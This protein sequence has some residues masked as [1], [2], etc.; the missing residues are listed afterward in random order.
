MDNYIGI[1][2]FKLHEK[3]VHPYYITFI[4]FFASMQSIAGFH[5]KKARSPISILS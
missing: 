3:E 1:T 5:F 2:S 4:K